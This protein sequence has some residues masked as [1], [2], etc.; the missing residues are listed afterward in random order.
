MRDY[1]SALGTGFDLGPRDMARFSEFAKGRLVTLLV[2]CCGTAAHISA[3]AKALEGQPPRSGARPPRKKCAA[4][5]LTESK[6]RA[7]A[8]ETKLLR[9]SESQ[10][11]HATAASTS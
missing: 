11:L 1:R 5:S 3:I 6:Q 8:P 10:A 9:L 4:V 2:V 7:E